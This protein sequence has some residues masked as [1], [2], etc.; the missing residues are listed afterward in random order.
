MTVR[1]SEKSSRIYSADFYSR[2]ARSI[3]PSINS[4][5]SRSSDWQE[6]WHLQPFAVPT[7]QCE[8]TTWQAGLQHIWK[9]FA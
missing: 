6:H 1:I 3:I 2:S 9:Y 7:L 8:R 5:G 4:V